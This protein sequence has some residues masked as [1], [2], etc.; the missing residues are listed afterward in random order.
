MNSQTK[1]IKDL[2]DN[3]LDYYSVLMQY[4][5]KWTPSTP[6]ADDKNIVKIKKDVPDENTGEINNQSNS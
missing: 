4:F 6:K 5:E 2:E 3:V 1:F